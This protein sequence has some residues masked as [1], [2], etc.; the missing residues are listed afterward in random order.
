MSSGSSRQLG[1]AMERLA[2]RVEQLQREKTV[3]MEQSTRA[4]AALDRISEILVDLEAQRAR[5]KVLAEK[6]ACIVGKL[7]RVTGMSRGE[8]SG[9]GVEKTLKKVINGAKVTGQVIEIVAG[10]FQG[11]LDSITTVVKSD[12]VAPESARSENTGGAGGMDLSSI[13]KPMNSL[14]QALVNSKPAGSGKVEEV[15]PDTAE[16][17]FGAGVEPNSISA[18]MSEIY[19]PEGQMDDD[20]DPIT[21]PV[22]KATP[23]GGDLSPVI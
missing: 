9:D 11:M 13:I 2:K 12:Q 8:K 1:E 15:K 20:Q 22:V 3:N 7:D 10:G 5:E 19:P 6:F 4:V 16:V 23:V 14:V 17:M 18:K 21:A